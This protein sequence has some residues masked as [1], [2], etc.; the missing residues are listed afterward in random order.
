[1]RINLVYRP[2]KTRRYRIHP[3]L[4][5]I[6]R[7]I[8]TADVATPLP[9]ALVDTSHDTT[10]PIRGKPTRIDILPINNDYESKFDQYVKKSARRHRYFYDNEP[11]DRERIE[12]AIDNYKSID[13]STIISSIRRENYG[14]FG[15]RLIHAGYKFSNDIYDRK[16]QIDILES[17]ANSGDISY[18]LFITCMTDED[19]NKV[20]NTFKYAYSHR[21]CEYMIH[22]LIDKEHYDEVSKFLDYY[23]DRLCEEYNC[24]ND[25]SLLM[26]DTHFHSYFTL[27]NTWKVRNGMMPIITDRT[28]DT[29]IVPTLQRVLKY[30]EPE[31]LK[32]YL[33]ILYRYIEYSNEEPYVIQMANTY[34]LTFLSRIDKVSMKIYAGYLMAL[35]PKSTELLKEAGLLSMIYHGNTND[36]VTDP[37]IPEVRSDLILK[38]RY[39]STDLI[40]LAYAKFLFESEISKTQTKIIFKD[41][42]NK[43]QSVQNTSQLHPYSFKDLNSS[44]L[45]SFIRYCLFALKKPIFA[46]NLVDYFIDSVNCTKIHTRDISSLLVV[47][48]H[49][50]LT[51]AC[52]SINQLQRICKLDVSVYIAVIDELVRLGDIDSAKKYY[53][54]VCSN[55]RLRATIKQK[56]IV[57]LCYENKWFVPERI[58]PNTTKRKLQGKPFDATEIIKFFDKT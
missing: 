35:F 4:F 31:T 53:D 38:D 37:I 12:Q 1:M 28:V 21:M 17:L 33:K 44:V 49:S 3:Y 18:Q 57:R 6:S 30:N 14:Y 42:V 48:A 10:I 20:R 16:P 45:D 2:I 25:V 22:R 47:I 51:R 43:I 32:V 11:T 26:K 24:H 58:E 8:A 46:M 56:D 19:Q 15:S 27:L 5:P 52:S 34:F 29:A 9:N 50:N 7:K 39:P 13:L 23:R 54:Y 55:D 36:D 40:G 41:F